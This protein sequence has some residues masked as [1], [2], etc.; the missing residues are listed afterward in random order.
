MRYPQKGRTHR[1]L[2]LSGSL[3]V[4]V[5]TFVLVCAVPA[6][7]ADKWIDITDAQWTQTYGITSAQAATVAQGYANGSFGASQTVTRA[8]YAK[9]VLSALGIPPA[10]PQAPTF[11]DVPSAS[12]YFSWIEGGV[13]AGVIG[14][15]PSQTYR[16]ADPTTRQEAS[17]ALA[18][19]LAQKALAVKGGISGRLGIY[20][21]LAAYYQAEGPPLLAG[22]TDH[23]ALLP[24]YA[25]SEA[26]LVLLGVVRG[27]GGAGAVTL[28]PNDALTRAQAVALILRA[29]DFLPKAAAPSVKA[30]APAL[31][32]EA[33]QTPVVITGNGFSQA[34]S[35]AFGSAKLGPGEFYVRSDSEID[36]QSAPAGTGSVDVTVVSKLGKSATSGGDVYSYVT[37]PGPG[38]DV[39]LTA[40]AHLDAPYLWGGAGPGSFDCSGLAQSVFG[41]LGIA[42]PHHAAAQ[43]PLGTPVA[44]PQL[45]PGDLVFF[46]N[47]IYHVGIYV[48]DGNMID[49]PHTGSYVR[50]ES[51]S[52]SDLSGACRMLPSDPEESAAAAALPH[53]QT[54]SFLTYA[55]AWTTTSTASASGGSFAF[56]N[57]AGTSV[58]IHFTGTGLTWIAK[59]SSVYGKAQVTLDGGD[60]VIVDLYGASVLWQQKVWDTG[61][62]DSGAH[63]VKIEW[64]G[65]KR[66][67]ATG[68]NINID[69]VAVTGA[70]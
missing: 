9:M 36:I 45:Q 58:T 46:G 44:T 26:Y 68:T 55:G 38:N 49:A 64:T 60:P 29:E 47:P 48:G 67:A 61:T 5:L 66:A 24:D 1:L 35:V 37:T 6:W 51:M 65:T 11:S 70:Q 62:L 13:A 3:L 27:G 54:D 12:Y 57:S 63:T 16:P 14:A 31:G 39:V 69:S 21:S 25:A 59:K 7:A 20:K 50:L 42:L 40:L 8:Q 56:A 43:Y 34:S 15:E 4:A 19:Y 2:I 53:E 33:G 17:L 30:V 22:F 18:E 28:S 32:P 52:W 41:E 10:T 23:G